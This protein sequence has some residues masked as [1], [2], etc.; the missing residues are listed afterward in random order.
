MRDGQECAGVAFTVD[1]KVRIAEALAFV[2][3]NRMELFLT[4]PGWPEAIRTILRRKLPLELYVTWHP[5][6]VERVLELGATQVVVW[7]RIFE[8]HQRYDLKHSRAEL[9]MQAADQI[10]DARRADCHVNL[11][12]MEASRA[13]LDQ[14]KETVRVGKEAGA[15]AGSTADWAMSTSSPA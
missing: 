4:V 1:D 7:Y 11:F 2:R 3:I 6:R 9:M 8:E 5:G 15:T 12:I 10:A 14:L 13:P